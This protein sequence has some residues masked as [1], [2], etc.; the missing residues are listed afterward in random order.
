MRTTLEKVNRVLLIFSG[1][2]REMNSWPAKS[3]AILLQ[4][5]IIL[6]GNMYEAIINQ[7][8]IFTNISKEKK[9]TV[10]IFV[11]SILPHNIKTER[12]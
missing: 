11:S 6:H 7:K 4:Y 1:W 5:Q 3:I 2:V 8:S 12:Q 10:A 9:K